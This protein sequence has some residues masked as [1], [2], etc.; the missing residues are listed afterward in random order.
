MKISLQ[1]LAGWCAVT[2]LL[3]ACAANGHL[4]SKSDQPEPVEAAAAQTGQPEPDIIR[5]PTDEEVMYRVLRL[6]I[7]APREISKMLSV[8][9]SK[10]R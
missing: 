2:L 5:E 4:D 10:R 6:S 3:S 9:I 7:S 1:Q 8:N